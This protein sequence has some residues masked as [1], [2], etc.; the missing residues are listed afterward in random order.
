MT[1]RLLRLN[2]AAWWHDM[3]IDPLEI[4]RPSPVFVDELEHRIAQAQG[5]APVLL[6]RMQSTG[7]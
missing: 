3:G 2:E 5:A 7:P 4:A 6:V 1:I